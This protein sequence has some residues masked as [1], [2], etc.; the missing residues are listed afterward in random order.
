[1]SIKEILKGIEMFDGLTDSDLESVAA[2]CRPRQFQEGDVV[3]EQHSPGVEMFI[4]EDGFVEVVVDNSDDAARK[5]IVNLG[6]GQTVGEMSLVDQGP[7][8]ATV[9]AISSPTV[10]QV[11]S[12][13][14]FERLCDENS[15][16]GYVV[17]RN[18]AAD[19]SFRLRQRLMSDKRG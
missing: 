10:V 7:R 15:R 1:M 14:D 12:Q 3:A 9:R 5:V 18:I 11:V 16:I 4:I 19:L 2:V 6:S 8:S 17:M 13:A